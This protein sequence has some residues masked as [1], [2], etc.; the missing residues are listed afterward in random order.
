VHIAQKRYAVFVQ[1]TQKNP[2][3][4]TENEK[5]CI[6]KYILCRRFKAMQNFKNI[7]FLILCI[8]IVSA[9]VACDDN[10]TDSAESKVTT[11]TTISTTSTTTTKKTTTTKATTVT[12]DKNQIE[13]ERISDLATGGI[14]YEN[15]GL[16]R[17]YNSGK[18]GFVNVEKT[19]IVIPLE[20]DEVGVAFENG[21]IPAKKNEYWGA[22]NTKGEI[23][24]DFIYDK[25][26]SSYFTE[27]KFSLI[28]IYN[29]S[30]GPYNI[31]YLIDIT[32]STSFKNGYIFAEL[33]GAIGI[34]NYKG[35]ATLPLTPNIEQSTDKNFDKADIFTPVYMG[36]DSYLITMSI[37]SSYGW[38]PYISYY[39]LYDM[40]NKLII[41]F[42]E[43][44][45][46]NEQYLYIE[47]RT[48]EFDGI[49]I[50]D[51]SG[52]ESW[53]KEEGSFVNIN[54]D[55]NVFSYGGGVADIN[56]N[57]FTEIIGGVEFYKDF[58][59]TGGGNFYDYNLANPKLLHSFKKTDDKA[60][61][62]TF[63]RMFNNEKI[64]V[65]RGGSN[66]SYEL[67]NFKTGEKSQLFG[68]YELI[69]G[70]PDQM[71][72]QD[73]QKIFYGL[74]VDEKLALPCEYTSIVCDE[75]TG[76][77]TLKKGAEV[78]KANVVNGKLNF[79]S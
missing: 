28:D 1:N 43:L 31:D 19:K 17:V 59:K 7:I 6:I 55:K 52:T 53:S 39:A 57:T 65:L 68:T 9:F 69:E 5:R 49:K 64:I 15:V 56:G 38:S 54:I 32:T 78:S 75:K 76:I 62:R 58:F 4:L 37:K 73:E 40:N 21:V 22:I 63:L 8:G 51:Y 47:Y 35:E 20:Y 34:I 36:K 41:A 70:R 16:I 48:E 12:K 13:K 74:W 10:D 66:D 61:S 26:Y 14:L 72:V 42:Q 24:I 45:A 46:I 77:F 23:I 25:L 2:K 71:I 67:V 44:Y 33:N 3:I 11:A 29:D 18:Y 79:I 50:I 27:D 60:T 30:F